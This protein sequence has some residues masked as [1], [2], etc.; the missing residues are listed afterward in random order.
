MSTPEIENDGC[1]V[2]VVFNGVRIAKRG[3]RETSQARLWI[4]I[5]PGY[6]VLDGGAS[7]LVV[8]YD[9]RLVSF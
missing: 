6:T 4:S 7:K 8:K 1:D 9:G 3:K 5:E 2:F